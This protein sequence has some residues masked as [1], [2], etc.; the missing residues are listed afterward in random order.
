MMAAK[1]RSMAPAES[2]D[3]LKKFRTAGSHIA[4]AG[5]PTVEQLRAVAVA[6]YRLVI[7][8]G[9]ADPRYCLPDEAATVA[10]LG[11][12]Y[13]HIPVLFDA[14]TLEDFQQFT[15]ILDRRTRDRIFVHCASNHRASCFV[16]LYG[17]LRLGWT[18]AEADDFVFGTWAPN[19]TWLEFMDAIRRRYGLSST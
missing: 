9:L 7:N 6:G 1:S 18:R 14:P 3:R 5:Q 16:A 19:E 8:L 2:L 4:T 13:R 10:A 15:A 11:M 17:Q 12:D